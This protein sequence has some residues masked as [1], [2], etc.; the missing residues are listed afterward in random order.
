MK[1]RISNH[2]IKKALPSLRRILLKPSSIIVLSIA[3]VLIGGTISAALYIKSTNEAASKAIINSPKIDSA[4]T[5][6]K[7]SNTPTPTESTQAPAEPTKNQSSQ[8]PQTSK[9]TTTTPSCTATTVTI[10]YDT[11]YQN[12]PTL[13]VGKTKLIKAGINGWDVTCG[14]APIYHN[15][16]TNAVIAQGTLTDES[17]YNTIVSSCR[18]DANAYNPP[19]PISPCIAERWNNYEA[20][21]YDYLKTLYAPSGY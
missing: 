9:S 21:G 20:G 16:P 17:A 10:P 1:K 14:S 12:D 15:P 8:T 3:V 4:D 11:T 7:V 13:Q 5:P 6:L 2:S 18:W 19:T